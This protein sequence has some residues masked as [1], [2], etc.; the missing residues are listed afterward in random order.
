[1]PFLQAYMRKKFYSDDNICQSG[2]VQPTDVVKFKVNTCIF[3]CF[4]HLVPFNETMPRRDASAHVV[5]TAVE[6][7]R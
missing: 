3:R 7:T 6:V 1:M 5:E 4:H 2:T